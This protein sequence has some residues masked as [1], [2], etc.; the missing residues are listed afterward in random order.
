MNLKMQEVNEFAYI[1]KPNESLTDI[2]EKF[3][4]SWDEIV[5]LNK[6]AD[7]LLKPGISLVLPLEKQEG[8]KN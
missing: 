2:M 8:L 7:I 6:P 1:V 4:V 3:N 5:K